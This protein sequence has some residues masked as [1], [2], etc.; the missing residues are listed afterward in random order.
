VIAVPEH[1]DNNVG[2]GK[3]KVHTNYP[4]GGSGE[5]LLCLRARKACVTYELQEPSFEPAVPAATELISIDC[6]EKLWNAEPPTS[7]QF[8][9][10]PVQHR[11]AEL[12]V[13]QTR[14][15]CNGQPTHTVCSSEIDHG[16][17][18]TGD[19]TVVYDCTVNQVHSKRCVNSVTDAAHITAAQH[20]NVKR[21]LQPETIESVQR[22]RGL[23][24]NEYF[25]ANIKQQGS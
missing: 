17:G 22:G 23:S 4:I 8:D 20:R 6:I 19:A 18:S 25:P 12:P 21:W 13:A 15:E 10:S 1:L 9:Y 11:F 16:P 7:T 24:A 3:S 2:S 14:V 5:D